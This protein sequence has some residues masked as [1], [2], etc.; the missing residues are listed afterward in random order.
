MKSLTAFALRL[1]LLLVLSGCTSYALMSPTNF[2]TI[3]VGIDVTQI[4]EIYG[5][6]F[7]VIDLPNGNQE[8]RYLQ[9]FDLNPDNTEQ[10]EFVF[11]VRNGRVI[12]KQYR[13]KSSSF[14]RQIH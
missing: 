11:V 9:R 8:Y 7:D 2:N 10:I 1:C 5:T 12:D 4:E 6:P 14:N 13:E 3:A